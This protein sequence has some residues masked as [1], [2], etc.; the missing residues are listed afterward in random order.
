MTKISVI[1]CIYNSEKTLTDSITSFQAQYL[2]D[3]ELICINDGSTDHSLQLL[4]QFAKQDSRIR[5]LSQ[6]NAGAAISRNKGMDIA[7]GEYIAFLDSDDKYVD[8]QVLK[9]LYQLAKKYDADVAG[10]S[11]V[12]IS[13]GKIISSKFGGFNYAFD[14]EKV[15]TYRD[16]Q[17][18]FYF[19]RFIFSREMLQKNH[20]QFPNYRR[21]QDAVFMP[22]AM[23]F[24]NKIA[25]TDKPVY[26]YNAPDTEKFY[27]YTDSVVNDMVQGHIDILRFASKN[28][29]EKL[30]SWCLDRILK[31]PIVKNL[32]QTSMA[33]GNTKLSEYASEIKTIITENKSKIGKLEMWYL[34]VFIGATIIKEESKVIELSE[35]IKT[36]RQYEQPN[37]EPLVSFIVPAYNMEAYIDTTI[38][39]IS[40]QSYK[41]I[42][43]I[44]VNDGSTDKTL[45]ILQDWEKK[46]PRITI[47]NQENKGLSA[48]RNTGIKNANGKYIRFV[49]SDDAVPCQATGP[50]IHFAETNDLDCIVFD[51]K[52]FYEDYPMAFEKPIYVYY[53]ERH[54][55][56][57]GTVLTGKELM[58]SLIED[59]SYLEN[60]GLLLLK[61][62]YILKNDLFF[63]EGV[64]HEDKLYT[65]DVLLNA[66][67]SAYL[68]EIGF[69]R[70]VRKNSIMTKEFTHK[71]TCDYY[72]SF[73]NIHDHAQKA[74]LTEYQRN[75]INSLLDKILAETR[76]LYTKLSKEEKEKCTLELDKQSY[77]FKLLIKEATN[78]DATIAKLKKEALQH[79]NKIKQLEKDLA[80]YKKKLSVT[81]NSSNWKVG[82]FILFIPK[83]IY[84][85]F[86]KIRKNV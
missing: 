75:Q 19:Q 66:E 81:R 21:F 78:K 43:I 73:I 15:M 22:N 62:D 3:I 46:D 47:I 28:N 36:T 10:G 44:C 29:Y 35:S 68:D 9:T 39:S 56:N 72:T 42:E 64:L 65:F 71:N 33:S 69:L 83:K 6:E 26:L 86:K 55:N 48:A 25:V 2:K 84:S 40:Q 80:L 67:K 85:L 8:N 7:K 59:D 63:Q 61:K 60:A 13:D 38:R 37:I 5:V 79:Q 20:V 41:N 45:P 49:D 11:L 54:Y 27:S 32:M 74:D 12:R 57:I 76:R 34:D 58:A 23:A 16:F 52:S 30:F 31:N 50:L 77:N 70:R 14:K 82:K 18:A 51:G 4:N 17:Q 53:Y 1:M 24:S